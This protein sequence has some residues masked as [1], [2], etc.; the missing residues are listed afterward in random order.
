[1]KSLAALKQYIQLIVNESSSWMATRSKLNPTGQYAR[2]IDNIS[3]IKQDMSDE[4]L[5]PHL[6]DAG[7]NDPIGDEF[8][9][10]PPDSE[11]V[12]LTLDPYVQG[13]NP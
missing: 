11:P 9:P 6:R 4:D 7:S 10:V 5:V 1:M 3:K 8:G 13:Y 2:S 12:T